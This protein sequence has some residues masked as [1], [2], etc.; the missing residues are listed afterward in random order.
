MLPHPG[1]S[2]GNN[3]RPEKLCAA[4]EW[5][6]LYLQSALPAVHSCTWQVGEKSF[7]EDRVRKAVGR[8][9]ATKSKVNGCARRAEPG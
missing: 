1:P 9:K 7:S 4:P 2:M 8:I 5:G 3:A 6:A